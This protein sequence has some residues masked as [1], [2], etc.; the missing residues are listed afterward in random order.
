[1][2]HKFSPISSVEIIADPMP[3]MTQLIQDKIVALEARGSEDAFCVCDVGDVVKKYRAWKELLPRVE[4]FYACKCNT[5]EVVVKTLADLGA[6]FDCA[7]KGEISLILKQGVPPERIIYANP[8]KQKSFIKYA[9]KHNVDMMTFD[10][11]MEL[12]KIKEVYPNAKLVLRILPTSQVKVQCQLGN[13]FG[14][15]PTNVSKLVTKAKEL[16]LDVMGIS[17]HCGSGVQEARAFSLAVKQAYD[18]WQICVQMG[19]NMTLLDIGGGFPGQKSAPISFPEIAT[20]LNDALDTYFPPEKGVRIISE[21]GRYFVASAYTLAANIIAKRTVSRDSSDADGCSEVTKNDEPS[22][23]YYVNDGVYGSFNCIL[24]DHAHAEAH[25]FSDSPLRFT[26]SVWGPT[27]DGLDCIIKE[28]R[29][30]EMEVGQW[31]YFPDM[32][33]YT[34]AAGSTFNG[35]PRPSINYICSQDIWDEIYPE[36]CSAKRRC[37]S[38]S[39]EMDYPSMMAAGPDVMS[40]RHAANSISCIED[41]LVLA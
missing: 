15:H 27:C 22:H 21:P 10:N 3:C 31:M 5:D 35:M 39:S 18:A 28:C 8:C 9:A 6:G 29:L 12:V 36:H 11:E 26:S 38:V 32:G 33:A 24:Y 17:F 37:E 19:F 7:S 23:M 14:C 25:V 34:I 30:P 2:K 4:P 41:E 1:M 20:I 40:L 13:K 16:E